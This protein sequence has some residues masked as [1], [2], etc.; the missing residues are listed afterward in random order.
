M[1]LL[2]TEIF[3][4]TSTFGHKIPKHGHFTDLKMY[5]I[6]FVN[7]NNGSLFTT[8]HGVGS[9]EKKQRPYDR[10]YIIQISDPFDHNKSTNIKEQMYH[11]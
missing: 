3:K 10:S 1:L 5:V 2:V 7:H 11:I 8:V 9:C 6:D 4:I